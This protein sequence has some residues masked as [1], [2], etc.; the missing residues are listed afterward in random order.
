[1]ELGAHDVVVVACEDGDALSRGEGPYTDGLIVG[2]GQLERSKASAGVQPSLQVMFVYSQSM[3]S[4]G[5]TGMTGRSPN[6]RAACRGTC[7]FEPWCLQQITS[8]DQP[9]QA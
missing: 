8:Q 3:A 7:D 6:G 5:E 4:R 1:M 2:S 9:A